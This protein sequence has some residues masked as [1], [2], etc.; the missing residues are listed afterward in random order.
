MADLRHLGTSAIVFG[1]V[2]KQS[3]RVL[4]LYLPGNLRKNT[5]HLHD[6]AVAAWKSAE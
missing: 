5:I 3:N 1:K 6:L 2:Y 4:T